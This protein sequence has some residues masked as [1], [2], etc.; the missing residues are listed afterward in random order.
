[1]RKGKRTFY[2]ENT[3]EE[4]NGKGVEEEEIKSY[5]CGRKGDVENVNEETKESNSEEEEIGILK[6]RRKSRIDKINEEV[7]GSTS[8]SKQQ[9]YYPEITK[10]QE[11]TR[12][13]RTKRKL[14]RSALKWDDLVLQSQLK[15][16]MYVDSSL[17][18]DPRKDKLIDELNFRNVCN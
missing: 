14:K 6:C 16:F 9:K 18:G 4:S 5:Q 3:N 17:R 8:S 15:L 7:K 10:T 12:L 1:M 11:E 13:E 2:F